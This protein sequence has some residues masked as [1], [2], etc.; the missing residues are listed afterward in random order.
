M[1]IESPACNAEVLPPRRAFLITGISGRRGAD[2]L[3]I[4]EAAGADPEVLE[5]YSFTAEASPPKV[6][7]L[8][9]RFIGTNA[10]VTGANNEELA[11]TAGGPLFA[12]AA[13]IP[14]RARR[15]SRDTVEPG[16][17][18]RFLERDILGA[19]AI[20]DSSD[21]DA[22][23][24]ESVKGVKLGAWARAIEK[25]VKRTTRNIPMESESKTPPRTK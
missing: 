18:D 23:A 9:L 19:I 2:E 6:P 15:S 12:G 8:R 4:R 1:P 25:C 11:A 13:P 3:V 16:R 10:E 17:T 20:K 14:R 24:C 7:E 21:T 5:G 22:S